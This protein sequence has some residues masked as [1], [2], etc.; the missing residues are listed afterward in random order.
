MIHMHVNSYALNNTAGISVRSYVWEG[1]NPIHGHNFYEFEYIG[2]GTGYHVLNDRSYEMTPGMV[3]CLSPDD[4]HRYDTDEMDVRNLIVVPEATAE[5]IRSLLS[6]QS[7]PRCGVVP[8]E[9][10]TR[11]EGLFDRIEEN[12][13]TPS[14]FRDTRI[15]AYT[16][17]LLTEYLEYSV[18]CCDKNTVAWKS[19]SHVQKALQYIDAHFFEPLTLQDVSDAV[20]ISGAHLSSI[21][22]SFVG[23]HFTEYLTQVRLKEAKYLLRESQLSVLEIAYK[24]G[25]GYI[26]TMNRAFNRY[27]HIS[28]SAYRKQN[29]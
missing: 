3:V 6:G 15:L 18:L 26:S 25:F 19:Y 29:R 2:A 23:C 13:H 7:F 16:L 27:L 28:P 24:T 11:I 1:N 8:P 5:P 17:A 20:N 4:Y 12:Y 14:E 22:P 10:R 21:F 9:H